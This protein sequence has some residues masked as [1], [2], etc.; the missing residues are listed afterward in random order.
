M[1][2][3]VPAVASL[4]LATLTSAHAQCVKVDHAPVDLAVYYADTVGRTGDDLK[5]SLNEII[6]GHED[7]SY[8][9]CVWAILEEADEDPSNPANVI[10]FYTGRPIP[11]TRR[12]RGGSDQDA[13]NREHI[14]SK[15]KGFPNRGQD[16]HTDAHH[17]RAADKSVNTDRSNNDFADGGTTR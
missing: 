5:A 3:F 4:T 6:R 14:W 15:S 10:A 9:P 16:A 2:I 7:Y 13:W 17:I 11:K 12:D 8:T 1:R